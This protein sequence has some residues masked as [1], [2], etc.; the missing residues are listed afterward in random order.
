MAKFRD[1]V[2]RQLPV[3]KVRRGSDC[4]HWRRR[5][6]P[7]AHRLGLHG[8]PAPS[9]NISPRAGCAAVNG[10]KLNIT[11]RSENCSK[12]TSTATRACNKISP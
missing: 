3:T 6:L 10:V 12:Q 8:R 1:F 7:Y 11:L 4:C 5:W 2:A 9:N